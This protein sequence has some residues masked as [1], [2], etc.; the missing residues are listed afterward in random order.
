MSFTV[1]Y[2]NPGATPPIR[3][4]VREQMPDGW[5]LLTPSNPA[6]FD[7][8]LLEADFIVV[9][10][11][12]IRTEHLQRAKR[13]KMIQHRGVGYEKIDLEACRQH[14]IPVGMTPEGTSDGVAEHTVL[15]ILAVYK[16]PMVES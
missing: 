10:T 1:F 16:R 3:E 11:E 7:R 14:G 2:M 8:E 12:P 6:N 5:R 4:I 13:L 9:A 15:L